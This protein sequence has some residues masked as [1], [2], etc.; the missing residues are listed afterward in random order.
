ML[1]DMLQGTSPDVWIKPCRKSSHPLKRDLRLCL[2]ELVDDN[3]EDP[4]LDY[5]KDWL[6]K[7]NRGGLIHVNNDTYELF[8]AMEQKLR[9]Y[10]TSMEANK[11]RHVLLKKS[12]R[13]S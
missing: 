11:K 6:H 9:M 2:G 1:Y 7:I 3:D 12:K 13:K 5:S 8:I 4:C 10:I